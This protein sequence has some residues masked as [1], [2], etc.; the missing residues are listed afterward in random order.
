MIS[1][2]GL[3]FCGKFNICPENFIA[4]CIK[5]I[6]ACVGFEIDSLIKVV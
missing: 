1:F 3:S 6:F 4:I 2:N 5:L